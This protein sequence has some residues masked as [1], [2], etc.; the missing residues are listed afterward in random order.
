MAGC[1]FTREGL[2]LAL[3]FWMFFSSSGATLE[4]DKSSI[5]LKTEQ[6]LSRSY[7]YRVVPGDKLD[8]RVFEHEA[9]SRSLPVPP[10]GRISLPPAGTLTLAGKTVAELEGELTLALQE[11]GYISRPQVSI[12]VTEYS[13]RYAYLLEGVQ[14]PAAIELPVDRQLR[15]TQV[16]SLGGGLVDTADR[17]HAKVFRRSMVLADDG[18]PIRPDVII[19]DVDEIIDRGKTETDIL[20]YPDDTIIVPD[21][22]KDERQIFVGGKVKKPGAY[23]LKPQ[24]EL[25]VFRAIIL[26][27]G[28]DKFASP[29][30]TFLIRKGPDGEKAMKMSIPELL[31]NQFRT[32]QVLRPN[33]IIWVPESFFGS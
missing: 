23:P 32:D 6:S 28:F 27:G 13:K 30:D 1:R 18:S 33:D 12:V 11:S 21:L 4:G 20:I 24:D 3:L 16:L 26:A 5:E 31:K 8:I 2:G 22:S 19:V 29:E 25:T 17:R 7:V 10:S 9:L 15:L 14:N